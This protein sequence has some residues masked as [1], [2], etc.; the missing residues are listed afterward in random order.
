M[1]AVARDILGLSR[2]PALAGGSGTLRSPSS[3]RSTASSTPGW[4]CGR[5]SSSSGLRPAR[6]FRAVHTPLAFMRV[7]VTPVWF[8]GVEHLFESMADEMCG[9]GGSD[10]RDLLGRLRGALDALRAA[11]DIALGGAVADV[12]LTQAVQLLEAAARVCEGHKYR[13][14]QELAQR[15]AHRGQGARSTEDLLASALHL[16]RGEA[17]QTAEVA[18]G[19]ALVPETAKALA[20]G[21]IGLGQARVTVRKATE[22]K[23]RDDAGDLLAALDQAASTAGQT[24]DRQR[25]ART[26]DQVVHQHAPD[27]LADKVRLA[28]QR[29]GLWMG[30]RDGVPFL[31]ARLTV[32]GMAAV[33]A[34]IESLGRPDGAGDER[35]V[36]QRH[37]DAL[38]TLATRYLDAGQL[39]K[40]PCNARM[41]C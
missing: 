39:P 26:L 38:V 12:E 13:L 20:D 7:G 17:R 3:S 22:V 32:D 19:L 24:M 34:A 31:E 36:A 25:L 6:P 8:T 16:S 11:G 33:R 4:A 30:E 1:N 9:Y 35:T 14:V 29:R 21:R 15:E 27:V 5:G 40:S 41:S 23:D 28:Q 37:H 10:N 2:G 18:A